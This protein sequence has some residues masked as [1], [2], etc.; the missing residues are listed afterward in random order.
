MRQIMSDW[1]VKKFSQIK[2]DRHGI[3]CYLT[4]IININYTNAMNNILK[5]K[6][7][8]Y[9][10]KC[11]GNTPAPEDYV[12]YYLNKVGI[13][14]VVEDDSNYEVAD[15]VLDYTD[16]DID[17]EIESMENNVN[18]FFSEDCESIEELSEQIEPSFK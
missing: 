12:D 5:F 15:N 17:E 2:F 14:N 6:A 7:M 4:L 1:L 13:D 18:T 3:T 9:W 11:F 8:H 10:I 16:K